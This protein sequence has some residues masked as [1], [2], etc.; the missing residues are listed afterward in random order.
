[1]WLLCRKYQE[2]I[3]E[4][5][6]DKNADL[7]DTIWHQ[8]TN[9]MYRAQAGPRLTH[10]AVSSPM[11]QHHPLE[12]ELGPVFPATSSQTTRRSWAAD[13]RISISALPRDM[14]PLRISWDALLATYHLVISVSGSHH[15]ICLRDI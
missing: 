1:M 6:R 11:S 7:L 3:E 4:A 5:Y 14:T 13:V 8:T 2:A 15:A 12:M 10:S 9:Q